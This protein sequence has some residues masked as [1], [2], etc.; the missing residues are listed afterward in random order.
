LGDLHLEDG[1][2]EQE[3]NEAEKNFRQMMSGLEKS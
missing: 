2:A 3:S 1:E